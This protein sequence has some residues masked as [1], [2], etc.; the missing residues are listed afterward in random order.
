MHAGYQYLLLLLNVRSCRV[1]SVNALNAENARRCVLTFA[2]IHFHEL[3]ANLVYP[4]TQAWRSVVCRHC[5]LIVDS[6]G[7]MSK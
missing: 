2:V 7:M 3:S 4:C 1:V 5:L 6:V